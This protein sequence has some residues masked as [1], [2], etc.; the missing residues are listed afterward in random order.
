M[1]L[2]RVL[3]TGASEGIGRAFSKRLAVEGY[4]VTAVARNEARLTSLL[5]ELN[6]LTPDPR[7][8]QHSFF[9][10]D[11]STE[12]GRTQMTQQLQT[13][14]YEL[15]INNAGYG[16]YAPFPGTELSHFQ[17]MTSLNCDA[18][19]ALSHA[20]LKNSVRGDA[21][22]NVASVLS[23]LPMPAN[24]L[25]AATKA[26]VNSFSESL[27][28]QQKERGVYVMN[29]CPGAT[30]TNFHTRSGG[31]DSE[32][33]DFVSQTPEEVVDCAFKA[34]VKRSRPTV[35]SGWKNRLMI[36]LSRVLPRKLLVS[37][38][39]KAR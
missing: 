18:L 2:K 30:R 24:A 38:M 32:V 29:L 12:V 22:I 13:Q 39:G 33:P 21:L 11:L 14:H 27:W 37:I 28:Y 3:I 6:A 5:S 20:F 7:A 17:K 26:F 10:A 15:L 34:L 19:V 35:I 8:S 23:F 9:V 31:D 16:T 25:Y 1:K 4:T 36:A